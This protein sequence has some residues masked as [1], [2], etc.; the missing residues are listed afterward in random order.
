MQYGFQEI[1]IFVADRI[2]KVI[3]F[4]DH[5]VTARFYSQVCESLGELPEVDRFAN[6]KNS[7]CKVFYSATYCPGTA[8]VDAFN[9]DWR[10]GG[11]NW[12]FPP[13]KLVT[14][15]VYHLK[16]CR[17]AG[18]LLIP[19]WKNAHFYPVLLQEKNGLHCRDV[20]VFNGNGCFLQGSDASSYFGPSFKGNVEV[21]Y[22]DYRVT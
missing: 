18:L 14:R 20:K 19:Q 11:L 8:G 16:Q 5:S 17:A 7:H 9:Y 12:I 6:E 10:V 2:S 13:L 4:D 22:L 15:C 21:W 1:W 3:D